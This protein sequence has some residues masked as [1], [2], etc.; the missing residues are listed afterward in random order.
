[1]TEEFPIAPVVG[2]GCGETAEIREFIAC[3]ENCAVVRVPV[4]R[5]RDFALIDRSVWIRLEI[6][7]WRWFLSSGYARR[8]GLGDGFKFTIN[9][10]REIL[11]LMRE[12]RE[13]GDHI[14]GNRLDNRRVNLR[15]CE[16]AEN[17]RNGRTRVD[18]RAGH[19]GVTF[20]PRLAALGRAAWRARVQVNGE[21]R[22]KYF[23]SRAEAISA[24]DDLARKYHGEFAA[25]G[26]RARAA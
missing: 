5:G 21:E 23:R 19:R 24:R 4:S 13:E 12:D 20:I 16:T 25:T 7:R 11:G 8:T 3:T 17:I 9:M 26:E 6:W 2:Y 10:H 22:V 18:N 14:D 1:M 15:V